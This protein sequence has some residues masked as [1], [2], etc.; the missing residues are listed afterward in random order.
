MGAALSRTQGAAHAAYS[1]CISVYQRIQVWLIFP[2]VN[3]PIWGDLLYC[4]CLN[5]Q[6]HVQKHLVFYISPAAYSHSF[7]L[8]V[9]QNRD[10]T[11][12]EL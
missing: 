11:L 6:M 10:F 8:A 3:W 9:I 5:G 1:F 7:V 12:E 4:T 2:I